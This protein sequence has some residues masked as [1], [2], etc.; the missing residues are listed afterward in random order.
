MARSAAIG[1]LMNTHWR[2][3]RQ[4]RLAMIRSGWFFVLIQSGVV[5][6]VPPMNI[7]WLE[8]AYGLLQNYKEDLDYSK[9][10]GLGAIADL[11]LNVSI[12]TEGEDTEFL[13]E[14]DEPEEGHTAH[15]VPTS[16]FEVDIA[17]SRTAGELENQQQED[18]FANASLGTQTQAEESA[19]RIL[20]DIAEANVQQNTDE[21]LRLAEEGR[22]LAMQKI[23]VQRLCIP[24]WIRK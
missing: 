16:S 7:T 11:S 19:W 9:L 17:Q 14:S 23:A 18:I 3:C 22:S 12:C 5:L 13:E 24:R 1:A 2:W 15:I 10:E 4:M 6:M 20:L 8:R 21:L